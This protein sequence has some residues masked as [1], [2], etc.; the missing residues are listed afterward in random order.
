M[1]IGFAEAGTGGADF[2]GPRLTYSFKSGLNL[3]MINLLIF[4]CL[5]LIPVFASGEDI[6]KYPETIDVLQELYKGEV[7]AFQ[8]YSAFAQKAL[9]EN[10]GSVATLF[11]LPKQSCIICDSPVS[12][13]K[14]IK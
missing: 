14:E 11:E 6:H 12:M 8:K 2:L 7:A 1:T 9:E 3:K 4:F 5:L 13:Y 10:Y